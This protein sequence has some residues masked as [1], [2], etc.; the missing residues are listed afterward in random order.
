M[1]LKHS[2]GVKRFSLGTSI[3]LWVC[4]DWEYFPFSIYCLFLGNDIK[5]GNVVMVVMNGINWPR[6]ATAGYIQNNFLHLLIMKP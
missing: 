1:S 2:Y 6:L 4:P 5:F 3:Q